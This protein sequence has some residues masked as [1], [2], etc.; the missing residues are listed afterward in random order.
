MRSAGS[1]PSSGTPRSRTSSRAEPLDLLHARHET[2]PLRRRGLAAFHRRSARRWHPGQ[3]RFGLSYS[4]G[5]FGAD[6]ER[7]SA[8]ARCAEEC[9]FESFYLPEHMALHP[10]ARVGEFEI[11]PA[12][13]IADPLECMASVAAPPSRVVLGTAFLLLPSNEPVVLAKR[14]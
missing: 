2:L 9:G 11:P 10:G 7:L 3:V 6:P 4:T 8:V 5:S 13:P 14:L 12:T 1:R